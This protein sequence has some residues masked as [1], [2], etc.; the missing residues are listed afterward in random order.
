MA[1]ILVTYMVHHR[2]I[3]HMVLGECNYSLFVNCLVLETKR[4]HHLMRARLCLLYEFTQA[5]LLPKREISYAYKC[6]RVT[7]L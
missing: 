4:A 5:S 2:I 1:Y 7:T 6:V 3:F